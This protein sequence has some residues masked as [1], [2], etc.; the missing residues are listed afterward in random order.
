MGFCGINDSGW[1]VPVVITANVLNIALLRSLC[2]TFLES[3]Y[4]PE[5]TST[6]ENSTRIYFALKLLKMWSSLMQIL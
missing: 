5:I 4:I 2:L 1:S 3:G 6:G